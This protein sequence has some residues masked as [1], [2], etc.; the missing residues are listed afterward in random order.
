MNEIM[1]LNSNEETMSSTQLAEMLHMEKSH[2][3]RDIKK[4]FDDKITSSII[5]SSK[6]SRGYVTDY[7]LPELESKMFVAKKD[8]NYLEKITQFWINRNKATSLPNFSNPAEAARAWALEYEQ[9]Q[10]ALAERDEAIKTKAYISDK[11]TATAMNKASQ[12]SKQND[13]LK[14]QIGESKTYKQ[15]KA[16]S[17]L[18]EYFDLKLKAAYSQI[19]RYLTKLSKSLGYE[20]KEIDDSKWGKVKA[21]HVEVIHKFKAIVSEDPNELGKYRKA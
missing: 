15:A 19:G 6:D 9:K 16:I 17:W 5:G 18:P 12:L 8:I 13:K 2:V 20:P 10:L 1:T 14:E 4:M 7:H 11:K 3:N 21:Y